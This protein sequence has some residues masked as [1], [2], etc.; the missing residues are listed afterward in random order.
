MKTKKFF[1]LIEI[2]V[3]ML[4]VLIVIGAIMVI[5]PAVKRMNGESKTKA[6]I[7]IVCVA[8]DEYYS[9]FGYYPISRLPASIETGNTDKI[10]EIGYQVFYLDHS[11]SN[12]DEY[13]AESNNMMQ[14]FDSDS[15]S[16]SMKA[17]LA[18]QLPYLNDAF[19]MPLI[20]RSP[21]QHN[22]NSFDIISTGANLK[23]GTGKDPNTG[24]VLVDALKL[25]EQ[26]NSKTGKKYGLSTQGKPP[27]M[28]F[29]PDI[30]PYLGQGDDL[31]NFND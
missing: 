14:F 9:T 31:S 18:T 7:K 21:G 8:L 3:S 17:D 28:C 20:Y 11:E 29:N 30:A 15:L 19:G 5:G 4:V 1:T 25:E 24:A 12:G 27:Y 13:T 16:G 22:T 2:M 26:V 10:N 6:L 23:P